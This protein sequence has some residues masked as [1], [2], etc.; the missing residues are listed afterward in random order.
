[1]YI[2]TKYSGK[3]SYLV[4]EGQTLIHAT[5]ACVTVCLHDEIKMLLNS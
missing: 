4:V 2:K 3:V 5:E 1:M